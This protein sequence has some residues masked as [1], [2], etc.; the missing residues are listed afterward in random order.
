MWLYEAVYKELKSDNMLTDIWSTRI[1][2]RRFLMLLVQADL[3][4]VVIMR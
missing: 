2:K 4:S 1:R 3:H